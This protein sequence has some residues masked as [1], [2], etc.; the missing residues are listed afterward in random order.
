EDDEAGDAAGRREEVELRLMQRMKIEVG[1][2]PVEEP[3][4]RID[5]GQQSRITSRSVDQPLRADV[6]SKGDCK[7]LRGPHGVILSR[8]DGEGSVA[9]KPRRLTVRSPPMVKVDVDMSTSVRAA[10]IPSGMT[11]GYSR[12]STASPA[13]FVPRL[14]PMSCVVSPASMAAAT[15]CSIRSA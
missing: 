14:P 12:A 15:A 6:H 10:V 4:Q 9:P 7:R 5:A 11:K 8:V 1:N 2:D 3:L 13:A